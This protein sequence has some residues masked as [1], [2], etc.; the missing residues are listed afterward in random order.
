MFNDYPQTPTHQPGAD[1]YPVFAS[2]R[3]M[4]GKKKGLRI[5]FALFRRNYLPEGRVNEL[6]ATI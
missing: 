6:V 4:E 1:S 3:T 5:S 2:L